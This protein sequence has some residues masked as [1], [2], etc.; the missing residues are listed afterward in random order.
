MPP[1]KLILRMTA[2]IVQ[3]DSKMRSALWRGGMQNGMLSLRDARAQNELF[4]QIVRSEIASWQY[5]ILRR[6]WL[7]R[8]AHW[9]EVARR[10]WIRVKGTAYKDIHCFLRAWKPC[11]SCSYRES[12]VTPRYFLVEADTFSSFRLPFDAIFFKADIECI[13]WFNWKE[14]GQ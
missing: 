10:N 12:I 14:A 6:Q 1:T 2:T 3:L 5:F 11:K 13:D 4:S 8:R 7:V 9:V